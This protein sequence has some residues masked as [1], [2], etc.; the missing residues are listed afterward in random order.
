MNVSKIQTEQQ[1]AYT[2]TGTPY[3]ASPEVWRDQ[4]YDA[5]ADMWSFGCIVY[6]MATLH[7]PFQGKDIESL[8][9]RIKKGKYDK[10]PD[11]YSAE[12]SCFINQ[13]LHQNAKERPTANQLIN[14]KASIIINKCREYDISLEKESS[15]K[16]L[17]TINYKRDLSGFGVDLPESKYDR[18]LPFKNRTEETMGE[19]LSDQLSPKF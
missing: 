6:Q 8:Y 13:C 9:K 3:Y 17:K 19:S 4:P 18:S 5:R 1:M 7:P 12:L 11:F 10:I 15:F 16:L 14:S 2:Q